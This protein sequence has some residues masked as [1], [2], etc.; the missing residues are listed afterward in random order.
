MAITNSISLSSPFVLIYKV[1]RSCYDK[2]KEDDNHL[3]SRIPNS[4]SCSY[5]ECSPT[6]TTH[7]NF[8]PRYL[9]IPCIQIAKSRNV[10][11]LDR[12]SQKS[13]PDSRNLIKSGG[14]SVDKMPVLAITN[15]NIVCSVLG[16]FITLFGLVSYLFK[17]RFYLSEAREWS[18]TVVQHRP[19]SR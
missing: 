4:L 2:E 14:F 13:V 19:G 1:L 16:G 12:W 8:T 17:E 15:F 18:S 7:R 5:H 11:F 9:R 3:N 10:P 6:G